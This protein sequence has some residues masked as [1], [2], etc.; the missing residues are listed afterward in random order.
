MGVLFKA[1]VDFVT[2]ANLERKH[3]KTDATDAPTFS[4]TL[5]NE[6]SEKA[7]NFLSDTNS[8]TETNGFVPGLFF[9]SLIGGLIG[10]GLALWY[11]PQTGKKTQAMLKREA[12]RVQKQVNKKA[13]HLYSTAEGIANEAAQRASDLSDQG[14]E[15]VEEK[16]NTF[17]KTAAR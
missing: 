7:S 14:R 1:A 10:A 4:K 6:L 8:D 15:F 5:A 11:A 17:K 12:N 9:G 3:T 13:S 2:E 16:A